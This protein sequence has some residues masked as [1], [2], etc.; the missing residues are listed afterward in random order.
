[1]REE[2]QKKVRKGRICE[3]EKRTQVGR[4]EKRRRLSYN[5]SNKGSK[6]VAVIPIGHSTVQ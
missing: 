3:K 2:I 4:E 6:G 5:T 1:M